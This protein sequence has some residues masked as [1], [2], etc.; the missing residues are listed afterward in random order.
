MVKSAA[1]GEMVMP[2][3][4]DPPENFDPLN[5]MIKFH[6]LFPANRPCCSRPVAIV[7]FLAMRL[8]RRTGN[9]RLWRTLKAIRN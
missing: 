3:N 7:A 4:W 5:M 9:K 2:A 1:N 8:L 6:I